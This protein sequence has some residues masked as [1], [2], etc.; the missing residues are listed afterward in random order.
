MPTIT[1][2][3]HTSNSG[4]QLGRSLET[5]HPCD[6]ILIVDHQSTDET[7]QVAREYGARIV[8]SVAGVAPGHYLQFASSDWILY[9]EPNEALTESLAASL[10]EFKLSTPP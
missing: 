1:A 8:Q 5:L 6:E 9:L 10:Y 3:L 2:L 7:L 4:L